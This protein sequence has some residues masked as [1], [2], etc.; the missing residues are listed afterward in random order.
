MDFNVHVIVNQ[1]VNVD[2]H[3]FNVIAYPNPTEGRLTLKTADVEHY[4]YQVY[5]LTGQLVLNGQSQG[6]E[7]TIDLSMCNKGVYFLTVVWNN[8]QLI[9]K[10]VVR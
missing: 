2:E 7:T 3:S 6:N 9:Q 5:D 4:E 1:F 8:N 10:I